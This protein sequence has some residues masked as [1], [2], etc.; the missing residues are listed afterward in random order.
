M[1]FR[2]VWKH[3]RSLIIL[4]MVTFVLSAIASLFMTEYY[5]STALI[6]PA[7]TNSL[8]V[9]ESAVKRGNISDFGEEEEAEQLLQIINSDELQEL[10]IAKNNL[11]THYEI[12]T[13]ERYARSKIRQKYGSNVNVKRTRYNSIDISVTD[14][15]PLMAAQIANSISDFTDTVK[16]MMIRNR[17]N[18][19]M[20]M[21]LKEEMRLEE[22]LKEVFEKLDSFHALGVVSDIERAGLYEAYGQALRGGSGRSTNDLK[23]QL[24]VNK[25]HGDE[26][27]GLRKQRDILTD[28]LMRHRAGKN[29]LIA[30]SSIDIPQKFVV[31]VAKPADKK[32]YPVRWLIVIGSVFS[33]TLLAII[34]LIIKDQRDYY[35]K[36]S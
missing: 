27:D 8:T 6:F 17:A 34:L 36:A 35:F 24:D 21:M 29:Q 28:Q 15:D 26:Y 18:T 14:T 3:K 1:L 13:A 12:D 19:S 30:D 20:Q 31:D 5:K 11:Y 4:A 7:R 9:N 16:N 22:S 32:S 10:V 2:L 25:D 23:R 33:V